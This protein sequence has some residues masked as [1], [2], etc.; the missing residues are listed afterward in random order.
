VLDCVRAMEALAERTATTIAGGDLV[1][2]PA[3]T[4]A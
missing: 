1:R 2:A 4:L 3:L